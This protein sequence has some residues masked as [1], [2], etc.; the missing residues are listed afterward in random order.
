MTTSAAAS[1]MT[2][3]AAAWTAGSR[4]P[5]RRSLA[6]HLKVSAVTVESAYAQLAAEGYIVSREKSGYF[7]SQLEPALR[8]PSPP[9]IRTDAPPPGQPG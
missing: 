4:L 9:P 5:S 8:P 7:V 3:S 2:S 6:E 1:G